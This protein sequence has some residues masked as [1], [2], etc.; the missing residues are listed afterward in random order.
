MKAGGQ[1]VCKFAGQYWAH[2]WIDVVSNHEQER[3]VKAVQVLI[4]QV[5]CPLDHKVQVRIVHDQ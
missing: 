1:G 4:Q 2:L 3:A 5:P